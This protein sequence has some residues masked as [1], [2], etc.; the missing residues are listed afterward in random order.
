M[1]QYLPNSLRALCLSLA[2]L[3][4]LPV[5]A[6]EVEVDGINYELIA[7]ANEAKV[8]ARKHGKYAR[9]IAIPETVEHNGI[10][11][12]VTTIK[13][14]AFSGC[15]DLL[16][17]VIPNTVTSIEG[18]AFYYCT[19]LF[20]VII[21]NSVT[22]IEDETFRGCSAM[23]SIDIPNSVT[24][25]GRA[26]FM[27]CDG[28]LSVV[29]PNSV[30][31]IMRNAFYGCTALRSLVLGT[32]VTEIL[33]EAFADCSKLTDIY[34]YADSVP[35][36]IS[37]TFGKDIISHA[38]LFVPESLVDTYKSTAPWSCFSKIMGLLDL[39]KDKC[40]PPLIRYSNGR[41]LLS[42]HTWNCHYPYG[43]AERYHCHHQDW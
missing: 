40:T 15:S 23:T 6:L 31:H 38:N 41:L 29:I 2:V 8:I 34:C 12:T 22:R 43:S 39:Q 16:S 7:T 25:I 37:D 18:W 14:G 42:C 21:P 27:N 4:S 10:E 28:L 30:T 3:L 13:N 26:A 17:V 36:A 24:T 1:K 19:S 32:S 5:L 11:Y 20:S 9:E 33:T 35:N